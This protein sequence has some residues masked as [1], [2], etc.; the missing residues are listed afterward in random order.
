MEDMAEHHHLRHNQSLADNAYF[1]FGNQD[2]ASSLLKTQ[3]DNIFGVL[4]RIGPNGLNMVFLEDFRVFYTEEDNTPGYGRRELAFYS[5]EANTY[6]D[7]MT[8]RAPL[9]EE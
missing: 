4:G 7:R 5:P 9:A 8:H 1:R 2:A 6:V 3:Y